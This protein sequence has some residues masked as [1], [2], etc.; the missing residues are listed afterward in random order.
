MGQFEAGKWIIG[1]LVYF[2]IFYMFMMTVVASKTQVSGTFDTNVQYTNPGFLSQGQFYNNEGYC[3]N[4]VSMTLIHEFLTDGYYIPCNQFT[5]MGT[6]NN[7]E[8]CNW[9]NATYFVFW[10]SPICGCLDDG[11]FTSRCMVNVSYYNFPLANITVSQN[12]GY[13]FYYNKTSEQKFCELSSYLAN[14]DTCQLFGCSWIKFSDTPDVSKDK[15]NG[16]LF[17]EATKWVLTFNVNLG[18][19]PWNFVFY[20]IFFWVELIAL[21]WAIYMALPFLH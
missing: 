17:W 12:D 10:H 4:P 13:D 20:F 19:G 6:C 15:G 21:L 16:A 1:L 18:L 3:T 8:N 2:F 7:M 5:T 9:T 14:E 11:D